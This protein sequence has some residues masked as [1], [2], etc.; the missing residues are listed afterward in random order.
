MD[1]LTIDPDALGLEACGADTDGEPES[2]L[3]GTLKVGTCWLHVDAYEVCQVG[4]EWR[5]LNTAYQAD[6]DHVYGLSA[7]S[8]TALNFKGRQY[9]LAIYPFAS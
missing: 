2:Y 6:V 1:A 3:L 9:I 8:L 4:N 7:D 5:A